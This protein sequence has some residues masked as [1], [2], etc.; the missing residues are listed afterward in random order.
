MLYK[1]I[2]KIN[3]DLEYIHEE[4]YNSLMQNKQIEYCLWNSEDNILHC[5]FLGELS[6]EDKEI[7]DNIIRN[8]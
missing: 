3:P 4:I 8:I 5:L 7:L 1:Y 6:T 2:D